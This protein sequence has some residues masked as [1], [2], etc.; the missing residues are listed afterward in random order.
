MEAG[1]TLGGTGSTSGNLTVSGI[2]NPGTAGAGTLTVNGNGVFN[3][4]STALFKLGGTAARQFDKLSLSGTLGAGGLLDIDLI[5]GFT[6]SAGNSFDILDFTTATGTF[7]LS[8]PALGG[9]L[10]WNTSQ[11]LT[12]GT[13]SVAAAIAAVPE[14]GAAALALAAG[15]ALV[16]RGRRR[17]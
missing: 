2:V 10:S 13:I 12:T 1:A 3:A 5:N 9:G 11:L 15:G 16:V 17:R 8:L 6:P 4:G 7:T 14:P